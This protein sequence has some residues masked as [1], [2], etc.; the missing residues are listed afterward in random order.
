MTGGT[1]YMKMSDGRGTN[2]TIW[3]TPTVPASGSEL[4]NDS[5]EVVT[6]DPTGTPL[7]DFGRVF[8]DGATID[9]KPI[10]STNPVEFAISP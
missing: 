1:Y 3:S 4:S 10:G 8:F 2:N 7:A 5:A 6:E 9:G